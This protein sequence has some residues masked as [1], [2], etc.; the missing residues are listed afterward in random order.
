MWSIQAHTKYGWITID[1]LVQHFHSNTNIIDFVEC[2]PVQF[3]LTAGLHSIPGTFHFYCDYWLVSIASK[4]NIC[5]KR[6]FGCVLSTGN[7]SCLDFGSWYSLS[8]LP[9]MCISNPFL[10]C[11]KKFWSAKRNKN[12]KIECRSIENCFREY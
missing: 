11:C 2:V 9:F 6:V 3:H 5:N 10:L 1:L 12:W 8:A 7:T 4:T